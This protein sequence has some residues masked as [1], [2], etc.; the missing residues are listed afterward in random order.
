MR[1]AVI[2]AGVV[3]AATAFAL[4]DAG[5][6]V[7]VLDA[8]DGPGQGASRANGAQLSYSFAEPMARPEILKL[9]PSA[10][11]GLDQSL[12]A[13]WR[14]DPDFIGWGLRFLS[15]CGG[16]AFHA[17]AR[18]AFELSQASRTALKTIVAQAPLSFQHRAAGKL[19][20]YETPQA[21]HEAAELTLL[22]R[23]AGITAHVLNRDA[24]LALEP[25]LQDYMYDFAGGVHAPQDAVGD[26]AAFTAEV[27]AAAQR[28]FGAEVRYGVRVAAIIRNG[29]RVSHLA[30]DTGRIEADAYVICAGAN[31]AA[32]ART[33]GL[34]L[35]LL[36]V[37]GYSLTAHAAPACPAISITD[38]ARRAVYARVGTRLRVAGFAE[39]G[40]D[41][42]DYRGAARLLDM[43]Q[44]AFPEASTYDNPSYWSGVRAVTPSGLP[45]VGRCDV[46]NLYLNVG[47]GGFGWTWACGSAFRLREAIASKRPG[48]ENGQRAVLHHES[49]RLG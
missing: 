40:D 17:N 42:P 3:G 23:A 47:H 20:L 24:C 46:D 26:A 9:L 33:A 28:R 10:F 32:L 31:S 49:S 14:F 16:S 34:R 21:L 43:A 39:I 30:A 18:A 41:T 35:P 15:Q 5:H 2:G 44:R 45:I 6:D 1:L 22:K 19:V 25:A 4:A 8:N 13:R 11:L 12:R 27:L 7:I 36:P 48:W 38:A 37:K 29:N